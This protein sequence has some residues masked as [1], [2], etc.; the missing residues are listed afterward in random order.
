[1]F[2]FAFVMQEI[3]NFGLISLGGNGRFQIG[4][5]HFFPSGCGDVFYFKT[6]EVWSKSTGLQ[7]VLVVGV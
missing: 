6:G 3:R 2:S 4:S 1:M 5:L 7:F